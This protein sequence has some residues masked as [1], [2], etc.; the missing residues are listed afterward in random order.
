MK[1]LINN[2][3]NGRQYGLDKFTNL[4]QTAYIQLNEAAIHVNF[5][6]PNEH[7]RVDYLIDNI[8]NTDPDLRAAIAAIRANTNNMGNDFEA[9]VT[10]LLP[11]CPYTKHS[12]N[13]NNNNGT[14][15]ISDATLIGKSSS[16]TGV[17]LR[18]HTPEE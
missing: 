9:T 7:S 17:D 12:R 15:V 4:H 2:K 16:K 13:R 18:W 11:V 1:F 8:T 14:A 5:Q 6:L 10:F 3:W